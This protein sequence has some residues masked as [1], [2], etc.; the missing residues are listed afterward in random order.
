[1]KICTYIIFLAIM[2]VIVSIFP[3]ILTLFSRFNK[4]KVSAWRRFFIIVSV[5]YLPFPMVLAVVHAHNPL[6]LNFSD[7]LLG[8]LF[9]VYYLAYLISCSFMKTW[10]SLQLRLRIFLVLSTV[11]YLMATLIL[12]VTFY[13]CEDPLCDIFS[14]RIGVPTVDIIEK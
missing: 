6:I 5:C 2:G 11:F 13:F 14:V 9:L 1:M 12:P 8:A 7:H 10:F 4:D 3:Y